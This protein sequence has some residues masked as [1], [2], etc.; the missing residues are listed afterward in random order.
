MDCCIEHHIGHK[1]SVLYSVLAWPSAPPSDNTYGLFP[2]QPN[3]FVLFRLVYQ[4][5]HV[6]TVKYWLLL[7]N[8]VFLFIDPH[9]VSPDA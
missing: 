6:V 8:Y 4:A 2:T 3:L 9:R 5:E 7:R 1:D